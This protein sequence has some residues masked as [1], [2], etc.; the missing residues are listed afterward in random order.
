MYCVK[1]ANFP[2]ILQ[3]CQ[4][5]R[6][7]S[8]SEYVEDCRI[9]QLRKAKLNRS[10]SMINLGEGVNRLGWGQVRLADKVT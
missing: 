10:T 8:T 4:S 6:R 9:S 5:S 2:K 1:R 3:A 7:L